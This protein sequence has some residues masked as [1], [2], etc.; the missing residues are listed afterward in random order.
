MD[1]NPFLGVFFHW[2]GGLAS[3]S[4]YVPYKGVKKW[5][6]ETY[7]LVGGIFSWIICPWLLASLLTNDLVGVLQQ[8]SAEHTLVDLFLRRDVGLRRPDLR[9]D[10]ALSRHV[11]GHGRGAG[12]LRGVWHV[13]A[14]DLQDLSRR[15][16]PVAR[17]HWR[18]S[19]STTR[20]RSRSRAWPF[21]CSA[22]AS[23][24]WPA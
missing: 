3:G 24:P 6:W 17:N 23:P 22:S 21:A 2:L 5:S 18:R 15:S 7:W 16:I 8:Q 13:G 12:L 14:A 20:A 19:P 1:A 9:P 11:A 4:F 10:D